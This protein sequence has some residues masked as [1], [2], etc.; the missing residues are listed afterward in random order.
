MKLYELEW[1]LYPRRVG[2]YLA[3][4]GLTGIER[5]ALDPMKGWPPA[6][7][8]AI[9]PAGTVPI[10]VPADGPAIRQSVA[11]LEYLEEIH[12]E[13]FMLGK[14]A[15]DR[16]RSREL[17]GVI[18]EA[19]THFSRWCHAASPL[20]AGRDVQ[21]VDAAAISRGAYLRQLAVLDALAAET[22]G[23]F[24]SGAAIGI[25][26]CM[27]M[28]TLQFAE[29]FYGVPVPEDCPTLREW[30]AMFQ[31]RPSAAVPDYPAM[32]HEL[33]YG[34]DGARPGQPAGQPA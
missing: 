26:D 25:A 15:Q 1:G 24:L 10:L 13:P 9:S 30:Y 28:A 21:S 3:E 11:I 34:L 32:L 31:Q 33:A 14:T 29:R 20:F 8:K 16:A 22:G 12:P 19:C 5:I 17:M 23:P 6:E 2:I 27:A 18:D 4:K 7:L